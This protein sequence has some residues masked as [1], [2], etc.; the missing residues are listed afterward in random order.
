[1]SSIRPVA[2]TLIAALFVLVLAVSLSASVHAA[3][4]GHSSHPL[5]AAATSSPNDTPWGSPNDTPWG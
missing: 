3:S 5:A 2:A 4:T 1:M